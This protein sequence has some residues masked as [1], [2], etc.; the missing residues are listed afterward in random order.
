MLSI[1]L[2]GRVLTRGGFTDVEQAP[3]YRDALL[4]LEGE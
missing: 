4:I 3:C 2:A 1:K